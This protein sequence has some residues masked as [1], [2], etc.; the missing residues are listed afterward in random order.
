LLDLPL[1]VERM[2]V[3]PA[4][5]FNLPGG[6]LRPGAVADVTVFDPTAAWTVDPARFLSK[7]RNTPY[8]GRRLRG[9]AR[10]T[11]VDGRIIYRAAD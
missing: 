3:A 6:T 5:V 9:R 7:G 10:F 4:R 1:L 8:A 2:S 11:I